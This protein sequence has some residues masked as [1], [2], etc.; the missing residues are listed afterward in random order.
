MSKLFIETEDAFTSAEENF[1]QL[2]DLLSSSQTHK[3]R[4]SEV[5]TMINSEGRELLR[6][7]LQGHVDERGLCEIGDSITGSDG[8]VRTHK[9]IRN[10]E[11]KTLFG[12]IKIKRIGYG[13][14]GE[15]SLFPKDGLL[16]LP[17]NSYSFCVQK[18]VVEEAIRGSFEEGLESIERMLGI[19]IPKR[20]A[21][22][23]VRSAAKDFYHF[24]EQQPTYD[25]QNGQDFPLLILTL[26]GKGIAM[27]KESLRAETR[28]RAENNQ[29]NLKTRLSPG[30]KQNYKR[31]AVVASVYLIERFVRTPKKLVDELFD[32]SSKTKIKR[33]R[34]ERKRVWVRKEHSFETVVSEMFEQALNYDPNQ[35]KQ[36]VALVDG[37]RKQIIYLSREAKR[38]GVKITIGCDFIHV[39]E[40]LWEYFFDQSY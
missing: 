9:R 7:L 17:K 22:K 4:L 31:M 12:P 28:Q 15:N 10:R 25:N 16:N 39:L 13:C 27:R 38:H 37:D 24:Y 11:I 19:T 20:Q 23:M 40:Y 1:F 18:L 5:E 36:W 3:M 2:K 8:I 30:E 29:H 6:L 34:P 21:A 33:P 14:R 35:E 26:D 32:Q